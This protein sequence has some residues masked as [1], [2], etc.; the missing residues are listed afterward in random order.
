MRKKGNKVG[1]FFFVIL[2]LFQHN[3]F[4]LVIQNSVESFSFHSPLLSHIAKLNHSSQSSIVTTNRRDGVN[5]IVEFTVLREIIRQVWR[6]SHDTDSLL[7][8]RRLPGNSA[9]RH[10]LADWEEQDILLLDTAYHP[11]CSYGKKHGTCAQIV[12]R[13]WI[14]WSAPQLCSCRWHSP[15]NIATRQLISA[16]A[17]Q[18]KSNLIVH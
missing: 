17:K 4:L 15:R 7:C 12:L 16:Q 13:L 3:T 8:G 2:R 11:A 14:R 5:N 1:Q 18:D 10:W 9:M 6:T